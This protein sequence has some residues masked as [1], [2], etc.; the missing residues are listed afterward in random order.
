VQGK[1]QRLRKEIRAAAPDA[2]E[3]ISYQIPTFRLN[4]NLVH[5]AAYSRHIGFYP[6]SSGIRVFRKD[7][8][9][10]KCSKGTV[11]FPIDRP[12]PYPLIRKI[13]K[14]RVAEN[15]EKDREKSG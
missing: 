1:L 7:L 11:Q 4:G 2:E 10:Y 8:S 5:F 14:F 6:T 13:V 12:L 3:A 9:K 15:L